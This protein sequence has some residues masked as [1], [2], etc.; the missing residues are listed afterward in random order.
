MTIN[1]GEFDKR[2]QIAKQTKTEDADGY[3]AESPEVIHSAWAKFTRVNATELYR[4]KADFTIVE[5]RFLIRHTKKKIDRKM[6]VLYKGEVYEIK[7]VHNYG[8]KKELIEIWAELTSQKA[9]I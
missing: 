7:Y 2:I 6:V 5:V 3:G 4:N 1:P 8:D 9:E